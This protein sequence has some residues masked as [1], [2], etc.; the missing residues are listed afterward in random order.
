M[1]NGFGHFPQRS[2]W[3]L[4]PGPVQR[5]SS[6]LVETNRCATSR[7]QVDSEY[8]LSA[9][10]SRSPRENCRINLSQPLAFGSYVCWRKPSA[11]DTSAE[12]WHTRGL[13]S[14]CRWLSL[15]ASLS[16]WCWC[17]CCRQLQLC[18]AIYNQPG[19]ETT[20]ADISIKKRAIESLNYY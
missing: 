8:D 9:H 16:Y 17:C 1:T 6:H 14:L 18:Y 15:A 7:Q 11:G 13:S 4:N 12:V 2:R 20:T 3:E 19:Q 5:E 10:A